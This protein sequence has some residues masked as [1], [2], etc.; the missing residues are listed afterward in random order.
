MTPT[1][2]SQ[3]SLTTVAAMSPT[4]QGCPGL[5]LKGPTGLI[6]PTSIAN[7]SHLWLRLELICIEKCYDQKSVK[8]I[9]TTYKLG[10]V[11]Q[12]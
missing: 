12:S 3:G 1:T 6:T 8:Y 9:L 2:L 5:Y 11:L 4:H 7:P 10:N